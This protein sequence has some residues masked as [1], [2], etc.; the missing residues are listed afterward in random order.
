MQSQAVVHARA[1]YKWNGMCMQELFARAQHLV[2]TEPDK[3]QFQ[4][5]HCAVLLQR[6]G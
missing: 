5:I 6:K 2:E 1:L 3:H 4:N